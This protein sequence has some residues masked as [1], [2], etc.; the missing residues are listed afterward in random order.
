MSDIEM[1][2]MTFGVKIELD[3]SDGSVSQEEQGNG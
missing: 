1:K 3:C 2:C